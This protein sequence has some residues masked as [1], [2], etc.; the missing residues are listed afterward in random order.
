MVEVIDVA[1]KKRFILV[2]AYKTEVDLLSD[3]L[4]KE[5]PN[6]D[7]KTARYKE[8]PAIYLEKDSNIMEKYKNDCDL[9]FFI[10]SNIAS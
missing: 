9:Q 5:F 1:D 6:A 4:N 3:L 8:Q 7:Y 10:A 2:C